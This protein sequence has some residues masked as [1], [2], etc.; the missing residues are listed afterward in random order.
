MRLL[1]Y[2]FSTYPVVEDGDRFAGMVS[3]ARL[4]RTM[5][6][7]K[8]HQTVQQIADAGDYVCSDQPL[9]RAVIHM[10]QAQVRQLAVLKRGEGKSLLGL[11]T[12]SDIVS[13]QARVAL[14]A[15]EADK[16]LM[17]EFSDLE[18]SVK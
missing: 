11:L 13:A 1:L 3:E 9:V 17:P 15:G 4:R 14:A 6:E 10:N 16:M 7:G 2:N 5:A 18:E 8:S 12:M